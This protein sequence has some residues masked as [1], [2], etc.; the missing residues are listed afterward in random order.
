MKRITIL[1][2]AFV[3]SLSA[4]SQDNYGNEWIDYAAQY[5]YF[6]IKIAETGLHRIDYNTLSNALGTAGYSLAAIDPRDFMLFTQ[7]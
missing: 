4:F 2:S 5:P 6:K 7:W 3:L 1:F